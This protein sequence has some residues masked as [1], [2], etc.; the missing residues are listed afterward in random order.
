MMGVASKLEPTLPVKHRDSRAAGPPSQMMIN[1]TVADARSDW[2]TPFIEYL[3]WGNLLDD[4]IEA[5]RLARC[6]KSY[7]IIVNILYKCSTSRILQRCISQEEGQRLLREAHT[8]I[9]GHHVA[10]RTLIRKVFWQGFY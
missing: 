4:L 1:R 7:I 3:A 8:G 5:W 6:C 9:C 2:T 10:P